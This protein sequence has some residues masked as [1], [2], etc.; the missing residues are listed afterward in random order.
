VHATSSFVGRANGSRER[1][2]SMSSPR[3]RGDPRRGLAFFGTVANAFCSSRLRWLWVPR[4]RGDDAQYGAIVLNELP[5]IQFSNSQNKFQ[6]RIRIPAARCARVVHESFAQQR[7][8]GMPGAR[9]TRS[10][11]RK[12]W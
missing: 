11:V 8:W 10:L 12:V 2:I 3:T 4:V 9:C 7:A 1:I 5:P 6:T